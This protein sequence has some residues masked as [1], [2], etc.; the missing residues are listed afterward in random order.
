M[1]TTDRLSGTIFRVDEISKSILILRVRCY[2]LKQF[3][4]GLTI[5]NSSRAFLILI[6][7]VTNS[8]ESEGFA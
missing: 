4:L 2:G 6:K 8:A 1:S 5:L 3:V 7:W